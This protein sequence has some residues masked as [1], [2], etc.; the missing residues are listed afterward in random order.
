MGLSFVQSPN[1]FGYA[2]TS[3]TGTLWKAQNLLDFRISCLPINVGE[4]SS[5]TFWLLTEEDFLHNFESER[6]SDGANGSQ[7]EQ[8]NN[9]SI[10]KV[11]LIHDRIL[12]TD[13]DNLNL[14]F[15]QSVNPDTLVLKFS[16]FQK[17]SLLQ[18]ASGQ[19]KYS[20]KITH[21]CD[22]NCD[23]FNAFINF[24]IGGIIWYLVIVTTYM[25]MNNAQ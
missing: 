1:D 25:Y 8:F 9:S 21:L 11:M 2:N 18:A 13:R 3:Y 6:N 16:D 5:H 23:P 4:K 22:Y 10:N 17:L 15:R 14:F 7:V 19:E 20:V 24:S 12:E